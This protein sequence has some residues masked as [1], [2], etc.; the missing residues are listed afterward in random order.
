M[1]DIRKFAVSQTSRLHLRDAGDV[2]IYAEGPDGEPDKTKPMVANLYGPGSKQHARAQAVVS[3]RMLD[4]LKRKGKVDETE[5][6][7]R[8]HQAEFLAS[9]TESFENIDYDGL[10]G[11]ALFTAVY[12]DIEIGFIGDQ[13]GKHLG[14][15]GNFQK[16]STTTSAGT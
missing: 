7:K 6:E 12:T 14:D 10:Q 13:V 9:C 4:K 11:K 2:L 15:W 16:V 3:N 5:V 8:E 1:S